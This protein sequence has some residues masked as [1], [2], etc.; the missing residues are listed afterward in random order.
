MISSMLLFFNV[1][2]REAGPDVDAPSA[3]EPPFVAAAPPCS[4]APVAVPAAPPAGLPPNRPDPGALAVG[5]AVA[6]PVVAGAEGW[7]AGAAEA[8]PKSAPAG[9]EA[10]GA[11]VVGAVELA[12]A[13]AGCPNKVPPAVVA[14]VE[15]DVVAD[16][17]AL[18]N[19]PPDAGVVDAAGAELAEVVAGLGFAPNMPPPPE[20]AAVLGRLVAGG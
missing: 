11:D 9:L 18:P 12:V 8:P 7:D 13:P 3:L 4:V 16:G 5:A 19:K 2:S 15:A 20:G 14:G 6:A 17:P 10:A 1:G